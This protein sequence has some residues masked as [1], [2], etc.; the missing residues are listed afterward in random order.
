VLNARIAEVLAA[1]QP[2][3][4]PAPAKGRLIGVLGLRGGVGATTVAVNFALAL[5]RARQPTCLL[6]LSPASGHV[7]MQLR[8]RPKPNWQNIPDTFDADSLGQNLLKHSS[9]LHVLA[10]PT[11]PVLQGFPPA[12]FARMVDVLSGIFS[13]LV[14]DCA[15][16]L[17]GATVAALQRAYA[18]LLVLTP[19]VGSVQTLNGTLRALDEA[20][21]APERLRLVLNQV[22]PHPGLTQ[23]MYVRN[24]SIRAR[25]ED[26]RFDLNGRFLILIPSLCI[27]GFDISAD[28]DGWVITLPEARRVTFPLAV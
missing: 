26:A 23:V 10:A 16:W 20:H 18:I 3:A 11:Q 2:E 27:H 7:A 17:D 13:T 28:T 9:G 22:T 24:G 4:A 21:I 15:P 14:V 6:D 12:R 1:E 8:L 5:L 25:L 19:D